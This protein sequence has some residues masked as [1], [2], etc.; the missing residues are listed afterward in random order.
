MDAAEAR[1]LHDKSKA[2]Q[3]NL[4]IREQRDHANESDKRRQMLAAVSRLEEIRL[5]LQ[6]VLLPHL[7]NV[8]EHVEGN[9]IDEGRI[10]KDVE[11]GGPSRGGP[12]AGAEEGQDG[13][14]L[15][16]HKE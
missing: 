15:A 8:R 5:C 10:T 7:P 14:D 2:G 13:V 11:N 12:S 1:G 16:G 4:A 9:Q 3:L 6:A